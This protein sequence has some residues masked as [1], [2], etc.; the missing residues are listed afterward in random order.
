MIK[1]IFVA[2]LS[3][4]ML[5]GC[6]GITVKRAAFDVPDE[7]CSSH[8]GVFSATFILITYNDLPTLHKVRCNNG[9]TFDNDFISEYKVVKN[10]VSEV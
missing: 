2:L 1:T 4:M 9:A 5:T 8:G 3:L 10:V 7:I 6:D